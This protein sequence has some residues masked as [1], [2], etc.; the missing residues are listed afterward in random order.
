MEKLNFNKA[1]DF[2]L[3]GKT[4][5]WRKVDLPHDYS[6][7][8]DMDPNSLVKQHGGHYPGGVGYYVK[9]FDVLSE[10]KDKKLFIEFEGVYMNAEVTLN[11]NMLGRQPYGYTSFCYD[12][13]KYI[14]YN[15]TNELKVEVDNST[16]PNS[17]WYSGSGIYR[18]VWLY[19][20]NDIY[21]DVNGVYAQT[22]EVTEKEATISVSA[23]IKYPQD[24]DTNKI[25]LK[26]VITDLSDNSKV[27]SE[28]HNL[29]TISVNNYIKIKNP[30]LWDIDSPNLYKVKTY[31]YKDDK[32][33]DTAETI[34]GI[35]TISVDS[36]EGFKLNG[37]TIKM[38]GGCVHHDNGIIGA[39]SYARSEERK[40]ELLKASGFNAIR[41][42][43]NPPS[44]VFLE[45]CD[46]L[47]ML[48]I[49]EAFDC[50]KIG[51]TQHDYHVWF[52][53]WWERDIDVLIKRDRNHPSVVIWSIGNEICEQC[54]GSDVYTTSKTLAD[55]IRALD[56]TRPITL[57]AYPTTVEKDWRGL[58]G[59]FAPLDIAGYNY[60]FDRYE[61]DHALL[62]DR[63]I[64]GTET[65]PK[66][67]YENW[68]LVEK[69][70]YVIGDF[71]WTSMDYLGEAA[72][73]RSLYK[74]ESDP[75]DYAKI[76][77][78][79][80]NAANCGDIDICGF[81]RPQSYYRDIVWGVSDKPYIAGRKPNAD[82]TKIE[83]STYW[84]WNDNIASWNFKE[85]L[86]LTVD[87]YAPG[88]SVE[89]FLN[90]KS[91]GKKPLYKDKSTETDYRVGSISPA[92]QLIRYAAVYEVPYE[93]GELK[94][95]ADNG[96]SFILKTSGTPCKIRLTPD[97]KIIKSD[98][99]LSYVTV[100]IIDADG[101]TVTD[102][103]SYVNFNIYGNGKLLAVSNNDPKATQ[104]RT[105]NC[106]KAYHGKLMAVVKSNGAG[107]IILRANADQIDGDE[108]I[109]EA[110]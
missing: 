24:E 95:V 84:G 104:N 76:N 20:A 102:C 43:H 44:P 35:R 109:I 25:Y 41:C 37:R 31:V 38:K 71:V 46:R 101:L 26:N 64:A 32:L 1:W 94:A 49:D 4:N 90:G 55:R 39:A 17:R 88:E 16:L 86:T 110:I 72:I 48:V 85:G 36:K 19:V 33:I 30:K 9:R 60:S 5:E 75:I 97:R 27:S 83:Y 57:G 29:D 69:L 98:S 11:G 13:S 54:G 105:G 3:S 14:K 77:A 82:N 108:A 12:M 52:E 70:P 53:N 15:D 2:L 66:H 89:L 63:V 10:W 61:S 56:N 8:Q 65:S 92:V 51:K 50:W 42:A 45:A 28:Q 87:V 73:G 107:N 93:A 7:E 22:V 79:P 40:V 103:F 23:D 62:P 58:D 80:W 47:G 68:S 106:Y 6:I 100:E 91:L 74:S 81:K 59:S 21:I 67:A 99:D 18:N 78:Y 34:F 96:Q